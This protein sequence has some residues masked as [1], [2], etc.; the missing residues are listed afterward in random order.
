M[1]NLKDLAK[2]AF[3][4][5][6]GKLLEKPATGED[7]QFNLNKFMGQLQEVNSLAQSSK[8]TFEVF[9]KSAPWANTEDAQRLIF[10]CDSVNLPGGSAIA[11]DF[12]Q[13]GFGPFDRR[14][15]AFV[16]PDISAQIMLDTNGNNIS[17]FQ[18]WISNVVN[19]NDVKPH[20]E[21]GSAAFGEIYYRDNYLSDLVITQYDVAG[22][23]TTKLTAHE[24]W[25]SVV[26]DVSLGWNNTDD[27]ARV[28]VN[29]SFRYWTN[30]Q[31]ESTPAPGD[32]ELSGFE[33][34][35]RIGTAAKALKASMKKPTSVGDVINITS[36][37]QT[38]LGSFGGKRSGGG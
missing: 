24:A 23:P 17:F 28:L 37:A 31:M 26:G 30:E 11:S 2:T 19:I 34:L 6:K 10:F 29:F 4:L 8:Y 20:Q 7:S 22:N 32:R 3:N 21:T 5:G 13:Q 25:P 1:A 38:F 9:L 15:T 12:R 16:T 35:L 27:I 14:P 33:Q 18:N 36:N